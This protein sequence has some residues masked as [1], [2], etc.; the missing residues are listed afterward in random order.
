[1][2]REKL[3]ILVVAGLTIGVAAVAVADTVILNPVKDNTIYRVATL[4]FSN[5]NGWYQFVG[6]TNGGLEN[7]R[8]GLTKFDLASAVPAGSTITSVTLTMHCSRTQSPSNRIFLHRL[9]A[10]WGEGAS[11]AGEPGG[12]GTTSEPGDASWNYRFYN[13]L[14]WAALGGDFQATPSGDRVLTGTG[15]YT[16]SSTAGMVADTQF[17]LDNPS[18]NFGWILIGNE[19]TRSTK[20]LDTRE[21]PTVSWRPRLTVQFQPPPILLGDM[22]CDGMVSVTDIGAFVLALTDP[23]GYAAAFPNCDIMAGDLNGDVQVTVGDIGPFVALLTG[24]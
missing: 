1:M 19:T 7:E 23:T 18:Q 10:D 12:G 4:D 15:T 14:P 2:H 22:N 6:L 3:G 13:T 9:L 11:D 17:W 16:W 5:G 24:A 20:R 21:H 8:R